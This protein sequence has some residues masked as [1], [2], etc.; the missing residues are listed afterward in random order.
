MKKKTLAFLLSACLL[1][2][3]AGFVSASD[4]S[5]TSEET[6]NAEEIFSPENSATSSDSLPDNEEGG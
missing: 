6:V 2:Q 4:F 3:S 1:M 5:D